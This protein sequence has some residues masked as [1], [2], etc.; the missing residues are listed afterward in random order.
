[1]SGANAREMLAVR[2]AFHRAIR[3]HKSLPHQIT[4]QQS[5]FVKDFIFWR[6]RRIPIDNAGKKIREYRQ[7]SGRAALGV[8][9]GQ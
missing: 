4:I 9:F 3:Q 2:Q 1:M 6:Q 8:M 7:A 5:D